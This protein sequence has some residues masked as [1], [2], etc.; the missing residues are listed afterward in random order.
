[1]SG[2]KGAATPI[3]KRRLTVSPKTA[4]PANRRTTTTST[5]RRL[6]KTGIKRLRGRPPRIPKVFVDDDDDF[7]DEDS[8]DTIAADFVDGATRTG[9]VG[10]KPAAS[11][12]AAVA[13]SLP[14]I[15][16]G[17]RSI[18]A[19]EEEDPTYRSVVAEDRN[20]FKDIQ[21]KVQKVSRLLF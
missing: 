10:R 19:E 2:S 17:N 1:M 20:L 16:P 4:P 18:D 12:A 5:A 15:S 3:R 6:I 9:R 8:M 11:A 7:S 21:A 14:P 13:A